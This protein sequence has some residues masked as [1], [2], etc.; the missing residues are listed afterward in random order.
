MFIFFTCAQGV[1][2]DQWKVI[3]IWIGANDL[4]ADRT[5]DNTVTSYLA[6]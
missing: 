2:D 6:S 3:T 5:C 4:C 1:T